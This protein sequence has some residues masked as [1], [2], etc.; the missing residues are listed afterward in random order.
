MIPNPEIGFG[1][2]ILFCCDPGQQQTLQNENRSIDQTIDG[3]D[4]ANFVY[5]N[6]GR[7]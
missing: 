1:H 4:F 2:L 5:A 3:S 7:I 6:I